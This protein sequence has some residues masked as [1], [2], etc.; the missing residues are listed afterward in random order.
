MTMQKKDQAPKGSI[1][2]N[3][4]FWNND[5]THLQ[6]LEKHYED[7]PERDF[8]QTMLDNL[9]K[10]Y[11]KRWQK[12]YVMKKT[13]KDTELQRWINQSTNHWH[14]GLWVAMTY[15]NKSYITITEIADAMHISRTTI[16][17]MFEELH[18]MG[19]LIKKDLQDKRQTGYKCTKSYY[20]NFENFM[21][22]YMD[23]TASTEKTNIFETIRMYAISKQMCTKKHSNNTNLGQEQNNVEIST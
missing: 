15:L 16:S 6:F 5:P 12:M 11:V 17:K 14:F 21:V 7:S 9:I 18:A 8:A 23:Y 10:I 3:K 13:R 4:L 22:Y 1:G 19:F 2:T 20:I